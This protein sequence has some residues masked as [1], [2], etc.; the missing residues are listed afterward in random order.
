MLPYRQSK[1]A[2]DGGRKGGREGRKEGRE[3]TKLISESIE[4]YST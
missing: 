2:V 3:K 1:L 4:I